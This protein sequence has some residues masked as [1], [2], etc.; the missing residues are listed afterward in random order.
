MEW[1]TLKIEG[2]GAIRHLVL[3]R[4]RILNA[5]NAQALSN[6]IGACGHG[7]GLAACRVVSPRRIGSTN[8]PLPCPISGG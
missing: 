4:P 2:E 6:I 7:D 3:N 5:V 8:K 1:E